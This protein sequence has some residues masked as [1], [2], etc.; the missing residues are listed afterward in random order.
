M[1][2][3]DNYAIAAKR[4]DK[5]DHVCDYPSPP[6]G[7]RALM[8][9]ILHNIDAKN[10]TC[11]EPA[12]NRGYMVRPL[13]EYFG[14]VIAFDKYDYGGNT[15]LD[16]LTVSKK[17][18][19]PIDWTITNPPFVNAQ[20]FIEKGLEI[21]NKGVAVLVRTSFLEGTKRFNNLYVKHP[22]AMVA[23]FTER[24]PMI[25]GKM[26]KKASTAT[27]YCWLVFTKEPRGPFPIFVWIEPCRKKLER[28]E[29]YEP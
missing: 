29:D 27:S 28:D 17:D 21:S 12:C 19:P 11:L 14:T 3:T 9:K 6:W 1:L 20:Q 15:L 2:P 16:F 5:A 22:P 8:E 7:T 13:S 10:L 26:S 18:L 4:H 24:L 23:Q 25:R